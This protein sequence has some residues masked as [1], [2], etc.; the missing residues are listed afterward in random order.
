MVGTKQAVKEAPFVRLFG[1]SG[2]LS[3][4]PGIY[5]GRVFVLE[6]EL[7]PPPATA[8]PADELDEDGYQRP[9]GAA[10][11]AAAVLPAAA[12]ARFRLSLEDE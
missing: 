2:A 6:Y 5:N 7:E 1:A 10:A 4:V 9:G 12:L 11:G 3:L 8:P